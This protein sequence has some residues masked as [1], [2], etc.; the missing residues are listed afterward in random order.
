MPVAPARPDTWYIL[1][2]YIYTTTI[3]FI[4]KRSRPRHRVYV[5]KERIEINNVGRVAHNCKAFS[6]RTRVNNIYIYIRTWMR[7]CACFP[8]NDLHPSTPVCVPKTYFTRT[9]SYRLQYRWPTMGWERKEDRRL[10]RLRWVCVCVCAC[11]VEWSKARKKNL[12]NWGF[13]WYAKFIYLDNIIILCHRKSIAYSDYG[14]LFDH[15]IVY[16]W[17]YLRKNRNEHAV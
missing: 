8:Q 1:D 14:I 7:V 17:Y 10:L 16:K 4:W 13:F 6:R 11:T 5:G 2:I 9:R 12:V 15:T 3:L